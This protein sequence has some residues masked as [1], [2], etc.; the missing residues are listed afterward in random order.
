MSP[1][2][3]A[4]LPASDHEK[5]MLHCIRLTLEGPWDTV[6]GLFRETSP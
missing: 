5:Q 3:R 2:L 6:A 1:L 4:N